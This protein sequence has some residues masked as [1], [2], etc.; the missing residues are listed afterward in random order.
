MSSALVPGSAQIIHPVFTKP[1]AVEI[2]CDGCVTRSDF[3]FSGN[4]DG[5][6][7][8]QPQIRHRHGAGNFASVHGISP[9]LT[10]VKY[11]VASTD[12]N[13]SVSGWQWRVQGFMRLCGPD[14]RSPCAKLNMPDPTRTPIE[15]L[16]TISRAAADGSR[17]IREVQSFVR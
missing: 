3:R 13:H 8:V 14:L 7:W 6:R 10:N 2:V 17:Q 12:L 1:I 16:F 11:G 4:G 5:L 9:C 15:T